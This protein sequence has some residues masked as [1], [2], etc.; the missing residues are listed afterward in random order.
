MKHHNRPAATTVFKL[1]CARWNFGSI[2]STETNYVVCAC[3]CST[4]EISNCA[5]NILMDGW[6]TPNTDASHS[7]HSSNTS[8]KHSAEK[9]VGCCRKHLVCHN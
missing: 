6:K 8:C 3:S 9:R 4:A 1:K 2:I 5:L 7:H